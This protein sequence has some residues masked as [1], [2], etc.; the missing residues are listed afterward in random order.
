MERDQQQWSR[1]VRDAKRFLSRWRDDVT[2]SEREDLAHEA[3]LLACSRLAVQRDEERFPALVRTI[4]KRLRL[5][6]IQ[7][8]RRVGDASLA[9]AAIADRTRDGDD[10]G[11]VRVAGRAVPIEWLISRLHTE[12]PRLDETNRQLVLEFYAGATCLELAARKGLS[13]EAVKVRVHRMRRLLRRRL[14]DAV[15]AAGQFES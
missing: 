2:R 5:R 4:S 11:L 9:A 12:L 3:A 10:D 8:A 1:A 15:R 6:A 13:H 7:R 14:E